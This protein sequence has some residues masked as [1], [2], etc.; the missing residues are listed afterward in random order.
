MSDKTNNHISPQLPEHKKNMTYGV[1]NAGPGLEQTLVHFF[2][3]M[4]L[5]SSHYLEKNS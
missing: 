3:M 4:N 5:K 2:F 1:G